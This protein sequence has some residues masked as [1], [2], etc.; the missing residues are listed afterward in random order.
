MKTLLVVCLAA[1][2]SAQFEFGTPNFDNVQRQRF[3]LNDNSFNT[4]SFDDN[5]FTFDNNNNFQSFDNNNNNN[6]FNSQFND[7]NSR[8]FNNAQTFNT[9]QSNSFAQPRLRSSAIV[10]FESFGSEEPLNLPSGASALLGSVS[11]SF[12][13]TN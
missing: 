5:R 4:P 10:G 2:A 8:L 6:R 1:A 9:F 3:G 11:A 12:S 13:C 7:G